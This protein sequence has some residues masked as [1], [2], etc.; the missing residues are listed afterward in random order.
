MENKTTNA[1]E[2]FKQFAEGKLKNHVAEL[3]T[4]YENEKTDDETMQQ[5]YSAHQ[6]LYGQ[7]LDEK[8]QSLLSSE[9]NVSLKGELEHLKHA[10]VTKLTL[11]QS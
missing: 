11:N 1:A 10:Y 9:D 5:G 3:S 4:R 2:V 7:E 8:I 6:K